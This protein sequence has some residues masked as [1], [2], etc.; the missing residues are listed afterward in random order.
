MVEGENEPMADETAVS[1]L[2]SEVTDMIGVPLYHQGADS[3]VEGGYTY[4]T[5]AATQNANPVYWDD[6]VA[7]E[8]TG[9]NSAQ[10]LICLR[11]F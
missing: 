5:C 3:E 6:S 9:T 4:N 2:P 11:I 7:A 8:I 1:D 10:S